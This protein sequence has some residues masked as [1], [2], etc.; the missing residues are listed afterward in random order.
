MRAEEVGAVDI[1]GIAGTAGHMVL[2]DV[3]DVEV[4]GSSDEGTEVLLALG[5]EGGTWKRGPREALMVSLMMQRGWLGM[6]RR[7]R[8]VRA[9]MLSGTLQE[10]S[11]SAA[12][13]ERTEEK[14]KR[15]RGFITGNI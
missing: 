10:A 12:S 14:Q 1:V 4:A 13:W 7:A 11:R 6:V 8:S 3:E 9:R 15:S 2:G 5:G